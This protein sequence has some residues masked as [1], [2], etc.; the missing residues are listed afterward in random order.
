MVGKQSYAQQALLPAPLQHMVQQLPADTVAA[1]GFCNDHI[2]EQGHGAAFGGADGDEEVGHG[3]GLA[4]VARDKNLPALGVVEDEAQAARLLFRIRLEVVFLG[5]E[6]AQ[7]HE[8]RG[9]VIETGVADLDGGRYVR[10]QRPSFPAA[11]LRRPAVFQIR[12]A[13]CQYG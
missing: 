10:R 1:V 11:L 2:F 6:F 5:E 12:R 4:V 7:Q 8:Q 9:H 3:D 13:S